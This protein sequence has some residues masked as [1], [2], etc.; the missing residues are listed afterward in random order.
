MAEKLVEQFDTRK[1]NGQVVRLYVYQDMINAGTSD[2]P[3]ATIPGMKRIETG[4][5]QYVNF[6]D[7][8]TF[9]IVATDETLA[10]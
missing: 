10:R 2:D 9:K 6:I 5:G 3:H 8:N 7:E 1:A 4:Q